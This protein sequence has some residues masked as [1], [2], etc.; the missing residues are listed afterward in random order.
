VTLG[1]KLVDGL[2]AYA[3]MQEDRSSIS[4]D[5]YEL[6]DARLEAMGYHPS[7]AASIIERLSRKGL[8]ECGVSARSGWLTAAGEAALAEARR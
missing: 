4:L 8:V 2:E 3:A 1:K 5:G 6:A 7:V